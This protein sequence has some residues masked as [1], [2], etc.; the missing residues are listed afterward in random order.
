MGLSALERAYLFTLTFDELGAVEGVSAFLHAKLREVAV[1][2]ERA[3]L[4]FNDPNLSSVLSAR[5][6]DQLDLLPKFNHDI[7]S[8][9]F[10]FAV[11][12]SEVLW[13]IPNCRKLRKMLSAILGSAELFMHMLPTAR[14]VPPSYSHAAVPPHR[15]IAYN[16]H[17]S[18]FVTVWTPFMLID[19]ECGGVRVYR[20]SIQTDLSPPAQEPSTAPSRFWVPGQETIGFNHVDCFMEPGDVLIFHR[21]LLHGSRPNHSDRIR[22]S[23]DMRIFGSNARTTKHYLDMQELRVFEPFS[24]TQHV[25]I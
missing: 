21:G 19:E 4:D 25:K 7:F 3:G 24:G 10:P 22:L 18:D 15:D 13:R 14:F 2:F 9:T 11:R 6:S 5:L 1:A 12:R 23:M 20:N 17:L 16:N 8:G